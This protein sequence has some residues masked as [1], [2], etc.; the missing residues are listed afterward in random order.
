M[1]TWKKSIAVVTVT[2]I[3][4]S[5]FSSSFAFAQQAPVIQASDTPT[6]R[7]DQA[8][9]ADQAALI[10][11]T[12][13]RYPNGGEPLKLAISD[14]IVKHPK[15]GPSVAMFIRTN[16]SL[17]RVQKQAIFAGL[18]DALGRMGIVAA[19]LPIPMK[20]QPGPAAVGPVEA[21]IDPVLIALLVAAVAGAAVGGCA[22]AGCFETHAAAAVPSPN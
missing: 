21:G 22:L 9:A 20:A 10:A 14:L 2:A 11:S 3:V 8:V 19:D 17:T 13:Q 12:I 4:I 18:A 15:L 16:P 5:G 1:Q 6:V 7:V